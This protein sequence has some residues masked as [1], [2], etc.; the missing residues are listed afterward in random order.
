MEGRTAPLADGGRLWALTRAHVVTYGREWHF[1]VRDGGVPWP[2]GRAEVFRV[3]PDTA[4][5]FD[6]GRNAQTRWVFG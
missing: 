6:K 4:P 2:G 1:D 5:R 3:P